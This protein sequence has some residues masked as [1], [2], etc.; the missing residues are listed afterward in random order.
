MNVVLA[1]TAAAGLLGGALMADAIGGPPAP[2]RTADA[3][4]TQGL[5]PRRIVIGIDLSK[6]NPLIDNPPF[7][8][9]VAARVADAVRRLG[10]ASEGHVRT[11]GNFD[12]TSNPFY[13]D[14]VIS[15]RVRPE[16]VAAE[17]QKLI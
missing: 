9:K 16:T 6:S 14:T 7:A 10:F 3:G 8:A 4:D 2:V 17:V 13:F 12:A 1:F 11:F 5:A 15:T